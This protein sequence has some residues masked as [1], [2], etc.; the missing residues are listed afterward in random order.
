MKM[1]L[2]LGK[3]AV[4]P[5][6]HESICVIG[7]GYVG[8]PTALTFARSGLTVKGYD[9]NTQLVAHLNAGHT[10]INED[11]IQEL[12]QDGLTSGHFKAYDSVHPADA[13][14]ICVPTPIND[15]SAPDLDAVF[16]AVDSIKDVVQP[17]NLVVLESTSPVGTTRLIYERLSSHLRQKN[18]NA[19]RIYAAY[20][21]ERILPGKV[22]EELTTLDRVVG[23][24]DAPSA[25][26]A[27]RYFSSLTRGQCHETEAETA[28]FVKLAENAFRDVNIAFANELKN[29]CSRHGVSVNEVR[30]FAN[31]HPRVQ[32]LE[33][34]I[35]VGG[36]CIP[37]DPWF[38]IHDIAPST[39]SVIR[40]ARHIN[41]RQP[42]LV[43]SHVVE[44]SKQNQY[45][46]LSVFGLSYKAN[47][48]DFRESPAM[49]I[50]QNLADTRLFSIEAYDPFIQHG[51]NED[52]FHDTMLK[53]MTSVSPGELNIFLVAHNAFKPFISDF[54]EKKYP[55]LNLCSL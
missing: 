16:S 17:G 45:K 6:Q 31:M 53:D 20:C 48:N 46:K 50:L 7:L 5:Q 51:R 40:S 32:I 3:Q 15:A 12:L 37:I 43:V 42:H 25:A 34:G 13:Y 30:R 54:T 33:S 52:A 18:V 8:L 26:R 19:E 1:L 49:E 29:L 11:G 22:I 4:S 55:I 44:L 27:K 35:G 47:V 14:F 24:I 38:L 39:P 2:N 21:P 36:H 10:G 9:R 23:G 28:E 41:D